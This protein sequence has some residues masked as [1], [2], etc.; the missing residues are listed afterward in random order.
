M[1]SRYPC[2]LLPGLCQTPP[3]SPLRGW[4]KALLQTSSGLASLPPHS[5]PLFSVLSLLAGMKW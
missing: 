5:L 3:S 1:F 4:E 2:P